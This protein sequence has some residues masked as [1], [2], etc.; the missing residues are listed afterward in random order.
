MADNT[1]LN[2]TVDGVSS[3]ENVKVIAA[4]ALGTAFEWYDFFLYGSLASILG[5]HFFSGVNE[6]TAFILALLT[7]AVGLIVRPFGALLFGRLG[8]LRGRKNTFLIALC[9]MGGATFAAGLLPTYAQIG[10]L[11]PWLLVLLRMVQGL[12]VGGVYGGAV[13]YVAEHAP[14]G[15]RAL[16]TSWIQS[17][18]TLALVLTLVVIFATKEVVGDEAFSVWGWRIPFLFSGI[19]LGIVV[20]IQMRLSE[21]PIYLKMKSSGKSAANPWSESFGNVRNLKVVLTALFG[22]V[23]GQAVIWYTGQ[24]YV[25]F[26]LERI[27]KVD[28]TT[29]I[30]LVGLALCIATPL[31]VMSGWISDKIGRKPIILAACLLAA[32]GYFPLYNALTAAANPDLSRAIEFA[33]VTIVS[34]KQQCSFQFDPIGGAEFNTSCDIVRSYLARTGVPYHSL[35]SPTT[36]VAQL[37]VGDQSLLSFDGKNLHGTELSQRRAAWEQKAT[38]MIRAGG[39]P[40][41]ADMDKMNIPLVMVLLVALAGLGAVIYGP[42]AALLVELFPANIRYTS[43][44]LPYHLGNGWFGGLLPTTAFAIVV[45]TGNIYS[46]LWYPFIFTCTTFVVAA[47]F[48]PETKDRNVS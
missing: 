26:F 28:G 33:P 10:S 43:M 9:L 46:G 42:M 7:F 22:A 12:S 13:T 1:T 4:S 32:I 17:T 47:L 11:A 15:K 3:R 45:A 14:Y 40:A 30:L 6:A 25:L 34:D 48:L 20:W 44:S 31:Y 23:V 29:T 16:Y 8:D 41:S 27:I 5:R 19:L 35:Y 39:Y 24:F 2:R 38:E 36:T 21:S 18:G 37:R